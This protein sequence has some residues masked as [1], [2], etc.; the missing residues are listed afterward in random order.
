MNRSEMSGRFIL[1]LHRF[2]YGDMVSGFGLEYIH[3]KQIAN[4]HDQSHTEQ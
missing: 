3:H 1:Y 4:H 2:F